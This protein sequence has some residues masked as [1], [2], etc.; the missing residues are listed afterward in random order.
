MKRGGPK[1]PSNALWSGLTQT[2]KGLIQLAPIALKWLNADALHGAG[3]SRAEINHFDFTD[4]SSIGT[5]AA[6]NVLDYVQTGDTATNRKGQSIRVKGYHMNMQFVMNSSATLSRVRHMI[7]LDTRCNAANPS[8]ADVVDVA[9]GSGC[10]GLPNLDTAP[11]RFIILYDKVHT[12]SLNGDSRGV[13]A[14]IDIPAVDGLIV[15]YNN[16]SA[17]NVTECV[18]P[19]LFQLLLSTEATNTVSF[20]YSSRLLFEDV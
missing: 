19:H 12:L 20:V 8:A 7:F 13:F 10:T 17:A 1:T 9:S 3:S 5:T 15:Q 2:G 4:S 6:V 11:G 16:T 18:G 14:S